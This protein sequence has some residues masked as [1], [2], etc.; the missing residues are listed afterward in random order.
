MAERPDRN[1]DQ[2]ASKLEDSSV[3]LKT[4]C[5]LAT[6]L[7]DSLETWCQGNT[8]NQFLSRFVPIFLKILDGQPVF[9]STSPEQRLRNTVLEILHRLPQSPSEPLQPYAPQ[10]VDKLMSLVKI[11]NEDNAVLCMKTIMDF[12]R[13]QTS[14]LLEKVQPFLNLIQE[15]FQ[16]ME[17]AV[18]DTLDN[19][20]AG[21]PSGVPST[22]GNSQYSQSPRPGSP[23]ASAPDIGAEQQQT[24]QL[25][26]GMSSF[27][28]L[29]ECPIIV[30]SLFQSYRQCV[31]RNVKQ[32]IPLI[33][34][35]LM[36]QAK[37]QEK[38]HAEAKAQ[39]RIFTGVSK[40]IRNRAAFG[41]FITAQVKTMSF[42][43][44]LLR[45]Y[46]QQL[47]DFLPVL[48]D[49]IVRLLKDCPKE[50]S[51]ARKEL[52]V[53]IRHII[54]FNFRK[55]FLKRLDELLDERTLIGDGLTVYESLRPLAYSMLADL[56]HHV[57]ESLSREQIRRTIEVYTKNLHDDY[58]GT[59]FQTMSAKLLLNMAECIAKLENKEDGRH[60]LIMILNAIGDKF[61]AMNRQYDNA[62]KMSNQYANQS[63]EAGPE[64]FMADK[65]HP[66]DWDEVD[67]FG[68]TPIKTWNPR[69]RESDPV[70]N[71]KF[72]FKNLLH[73]LKNLFYQLRA[74]NPPNTI[75]KANTPANW[76]EVSY[77]F[78]AEEVEVFVKLLREGAHVFRYYSLDEPPT[79][80]QSMSPVELLANHHM[81]ASSKEEKELLESF[82]TVF[83]HV[84]P[85]TFHEIFHSEIPHLY[86]MMFEHPSLLHIPQFLLASEATSPAFAGMLFQFLM[87]R[88]DDV[89]SKDVK[90]ASILLRL[91]KLAFMAVTLFSQ[92]NEP[93]LLPHVTK[94]ITKSIQLSTTAEEPINYFILLRSLFRSIGGGRFEHLYKEILPLLEML[95]EVLNNLLQSA[96]KQSDRDLYVELS[97]T[98]PARL[99]NLLPH[100]SYLMRPLVVALGAGTELVAQGLRTLELCVDNLTADYLDP[101]MAPVIDELMAALW[102]HL[103]P[104]P[105]TH[106]HAHTTMRILG[107]LGGRNRKFL[108]RPPPLD[109][110]EYADDECSIDIK[111]IGSTRDR[112]MPVRMGIDVAIE[113]LSDM[114]K[115]ASAKQSDLFYKRH[116]F[117]LIT[118]ELKL[119]IGADNLPDD[120]AQLVRLQ[121]NDLREGKYD[122]GTDLLAISEREKSTAKRDSEQGTLRKLLN[123]LILACTLPDLKDEASA[124]LNNV[125]RHFAILEVGKALAIEKHRQKPFDV[126]SGEGPVVLDSNVLADSLMDSLSSEKIEVREV[127]ERTILNVRDM[128]TTIFGS[129]DR[130]DKFT[131]FVHLQRTFS[132][133]C[134]EEQWFTKAGGALGLDIMVSKLGLSDEWLV[135]R[136]RELVVALLYV[137][138][139][140]PSD[141]PANMRA[142]AQS[143]IEHILQRCHKNSTKEDL[144]N[145]TSKLSV[146]CATLVMELNH[147]NKHV[148]DATQ[149]IFGVLAKVVGVEVYEL[150]A[151]V[152]ERILKP[153]YLKPI[154]ALPFAHQIGHID[155]M[156]FLLKLEHGIVEINE[157]TNRLLME[158]LALAD[159]DD[160]HL[161]P[162]PLEQ[163]NAELVIKFRVACIR[164]LSTAMD[165][166]E[167]Q[168]TPNSTTSRAR[169]I[170]VFFKSLYSKAPD[171]VEAAEL[172]LKGVL[173][174][175]HKLP[176]DLLQNGLR[177]ILMNL[178]DP[179]KLSVDGLEGLAKLLTL[180][181]NYFKVE[182]GSRLLD[183]TKTIADPTSLQK[184]SF[185]LI[186]QNRQMKVI[187]AILNVFHLLPPQALGFLDQLVQKVLE[188]EKDLRRTHYSP[189][190]KP[191]IQYLNRYSSEAWTYFKER[192]K[193]HLHGRFFAQLLSDPLSG[194][195]RE[196]VTSDLTGFQSALTMDTEKNE[197]WIAAMNAIHA[198]KSICSFPETS[199]WLVENLD[200]RK[201]LLASAITLERKLRD[202]AIDTHL[203]LSAEQSGDQM[204][205][206]IN[207]Y[208]SND[209][210]NFDFLFEVIDAITAGNLKDCPS[211]V[212]FIYEKLVCNDSVDYQRSLVVRGIEQYGSRN[213]SQ[214][215]KTYALHYIV[216]PIFAMDI[217]RNWD[218]LW[219]MSKGT[220]LFDKPML[221]TVHNKLWK[222]AST[223]ALVEDGRSGVDHSRLELLQLTTLLVKYHAG[224][225][226]DARKD[227]IKFGWNYIKLEDIIN[228]QAAYVLI[229]YFIAQYDTPAKITLQVYQALLKAH[230]NEGRALVAQGMEV[231]APMLPKRV[232][233]VG[234]KK[235]PVWAK[236]AKRILVEESSN[237]Q[238]LTSIFQFIVRHEDL[239]YEARES[240]A[241][242]IMQSLTKIASPPNP[243]NDQK[244]LALNLITLIWKWEERAS[245]EAASSTPG[246]PVSMKRRVDG[247]EVANNLT[248]S[249]PQRGF[250]ANSQLRLM[251]VK[252]LVQFIAYIP[253]RYPVP[254]AADKE[255]DQYQNIHQSQGVEMCKKSLRLLQGLLSP[256]YWSDLD[257]DNLFPRVTEQILTSEPKPEEKPEAWTTKIVNTLQILKVLVNVKSDEWVLGRLEQLQKLLEKP[258]RSEN[259]EIQDC[260]HTLDEDEAEEGRTKLVPLV[261]RILD[262]VP[263]EKEADE[264]EGAM[265]EDKDKPEIITYLSNVASEMISGGNYVSSINI[266]W[267]LSKRKPAELDQH[268][269]QVMKAL[270]TKLAKDHLAAQTSPQIPGGMQNPRPGGP[271]D[272]VPDP[273][274][275]EI[276]TDLIL[277]VIE[278]VAVRMSQLG[279][280]RRPYL[281]VL[282]SLV[283]RSQSSAICS[284]ILDMVSE[285]VFDSVEPVPT[286]KEK[287]AVLHKMLIFEQKADEALLNKFLDLV[288]RIYEDPKITRSELTVRMEYAFLIGTRAHNVEMRNR[289]MSIFDKSLSRTA[290]NR[291]KYVLASQNWDTLGE[292]FWLKQVIQLLFGSVEMHSHTSLHHEDF[293]VPPASLFFG[294]YKGDERL[295]SVMLDDKLE[296]LIH[297]HKAFNASLSDVRTR[298]ILE[299]LSQLQHTDDD[300]AHNIWVAF[301]PICW[302]VLTKDDRAELEK[303]LVALLTKDFHQRQIDRRPNCVG[304]ILEGI[305]KAQP[306]PKF[307]S[308]ILKY[309]ARTYDAWYVAARMLEDY[310]IEPLVDTPKIRESNLDALLEIYSSLEEDDLFYGT[311]R[312]RCQFVETNAALSY[313]Q[314]GMWDK[315]QQMYETAQ[316]KARTGTLP[317]AQGEYMLWEDHWVHCAQKLQQWEIL[318]DFAKHE[319]FNDLYL[320]STWRTFEAWTN[321][322]HRE[323]LDSIV[324]SVSDA[325]TMRRVFFQAF[326]ALLKM[327]SKQESQ[328]ELNRLIDENIQLSIRK[329]HQLP[330][331]IT[332]AHIPILQNFQQLVEL[333][334]A[335]V[336][337]NSL[338]QTSAQNLDMKSQE[339][340]M[341]LGTWRDRLP[342]FWDDINAWQSLVTWRQHIFQLING[343]Y[344]NL[345]PPQAGSATGSSFAY[346][347]YHETAWIINRFAHVARKHQMPEV[348]IN[349]LSRIYTLPNIEIQEAFLKLREQAKC[350][351]QN[352]AELSSGLDV[353]N[354]TN[355]SYFGAQ[356]K[357]EFYTLKGMF[358]DKLGDK[359]AANDAFGS[360]LYFDIKLPKAW[361]EWGRYNDMLF[362]VDPKAIDKG[363]NAISCYL[364][365]AG[366][367]KS[368]KSRKLISRV[369]W[370][371]SLDDGEETLAKAFEAYKG[372]TPVWYWITFIPQLLLGLSRPE[373]RLLRSVLLK[374]AK[375]YP[376]ALYFQLRTS[377]EDLLAIKKQNEAKAKQAKERA[378]AQ[379]QQNGDTGKQASPSSRPGTGDGGSSRPGTANGDT[380]QAPSQNSGQDAA[381]TNGA[382]QATPKTEAADGAN[383]NTSAQAKSQDKDKQP[384]DHADELMT[385]LKT[386]YP[387][388]SLS[389]EQLVDSMQQKF[390]CPPDEDAYRL[391]VALLNDGLQW[392]GR[393]PAQYAKTQKLPAP[394]EMNIT[395]FSESILPTHIRKFFE[396]DF[397]KVKPTAYEY[398][399]KLRKWRDR[400]E[401]KL[402]RRNPRANLEH[403]S[404]VLNDFRFQKFDDV[405]VPGQ[406]LEHRDKNQDF[407]RIERLMPTVDLVRGIGVCHRRIRIRGHDGSVHPFAVQHPASRSSR[408][409]ERML[410]LF[411]TF[412]STLAKKKESRRRN[413][414]FHLPEMIP[415]SPHVRLVQDDPSYITLQGVYEDYARQNNFS[416]DE[417]ILFTIEKLQKLSSTRRDVETS[418]KMDTFNAVQDKYVPQSLLKDYMQALYPSFA[419]YFLFRRQFAYQFATLTFMTYII[420]MTQRY[421]HK[422][423]ISRSTGDVWGVDLLPSI[424]SSRPIFINTEPVPFRLTPNV[425]VFLGPLAMEGIFA[426]VLQTLSRC[427]V[428][429]LSSSSDDGPAPSTQPTGAAS[430]ASGSTADAAKENATGSAGIDLDMQLSI[431]IRDEVHF[432]FTQAHRQPPTTDQLREHV[433][434]NSKSIVKKTLSLASSPDMNNLP[435][436]QTAIDLI[437][438]AVA[439]ML[440]CQTDPLWMGY[441]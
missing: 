169:I 58:P 408:R 48:P 257:F 384:W 167:F 233:E 115:P 405:E 247:T 143:T 211:F 343:T 230:Q 196:A 37:P 39:G 102:R 64:D 67:I 152:K 184:I 151:P 68:A 389:M 99:S 284:K 114:T 57:R 5:A 108:N 406:Y 162:K 425:Q 51:A 381:N 303:G 400:F 7:R 62:I 314:N 429:P 323:Q 122:A 171:V 187:T 412:N 223:E 159:S 146:M 61:A 72:L 246:S 100:L 401:E 44:Y 386:A 361:A 313:E 140:L 362:R 414:K 92:Q 269:P 200:L 239:F 116:A 245:K 347:G 195:L 182:I 280:Q 407:I 294:T 379:G 320:E 243:S 160:E 123:A 198:A 272:G 416:K 420:P 432:W 339:L 309:L 23:A 415:L 94:L 134:Y 197:R 281:S 153:I 20:S 163:R 438:K 237:L 126:M 357:A 52:L 241:P 317:F 210:R 36:L 387:L 17:Q 2:I 227:V 222:P 74:C 350:H 148:R 345:V 433:M 192:L 369:L 380:S 235:I 40:E 353:I 300:L 248:S 119:F 9:I 16:M 279:E 75:D 371:L 385:V 301:F 6:E 168:D 66:P 174:A 393:Q 70:S 249:S 80:Y 298:D 267:T 250:V 234:D 383:G 421:P 206:I 364:E 128:V 41:E 355:L 47:T 203:R 367:Y 228:K 131:F 330:K 14:V 399:H 325:P 42:L 329:W 296:S 287:T 306:R 189:F 352:K 87:A 19:T 31:P 229:A 358:Q 137:M 372:E 43:A 288:I 179:R 354:N 4:K 69:D 439:P 21:A 266:L 242:T 13:H 30:V 344:L 252:Y 129:A 312:R 366:Q 91:F 53:A 35:I 110:K 136:Q 207:V 318:S 390:K 426:C 226:I 302:S 342:N 204:M 65:N 142:Q 173:A 370:L 49:I 111:M 289:F 417:P 262:A 441:L 274:E 135:D 77:G 322:E 253:E 319:N 327:H 291:V 396:Q 340:K 185:T 22:P 124:M 424:H 117:K 63:M 292:S 410:Q 133:A 324:K 268:I 283:E 98:V 150:V 158:S 105:Y 15:M 404:Q 332:K 368:A 161:T 276:I 132:H 402:D 213:A 336:I 376:Q 328:P 93:V 270:Q 194:P 127:A 260:L 154:R 377:K 212:T 436:N 236:M 60:F 145:H 232:G 199:K 321:N 391:I 144:A 346:R 113:K 295:N 261:K 12:E 428:E 89:G 24:R 50:K 258:L 378:Q 101:I 365:A 373:A 286:L 103:R 437:A 28:V 382:A 170:A 397:V 73:G 351:Y 120:F 231:L 216:N 175:T 221:E 338:S 141:L 97:L 434:G 348:C 155:A 25:I 180:L 139:D 125:C 251:M 259:P 311:W 217:K 118:S 176:K 411:R 188:L 107:K 76:A 149:K 392:I 305:G 11:E 32:F 190:R 86:D 56:I 431:F 275:Q 419:D 277:K 398:I 104:A 85:A 33:K 430:T 409:E 26:K 435:C 1:P 208:L 215:T 331:R 83:H 225:V 423:A 96:R 95:L 334:D 224:M 177:P 337:S 27:K 403:Y 240:L 374:I 271:Q 186:E 244:K 220:K 218:S 46:A 112:A 164:L 326:L 285:W 422:I 165:F 304:T 147:L 54:N 308:H 191:L 8:Y 363:G 29:A 394:T 440:L 79:D 290:S 214:K 81:V 166:K 10:I 413:L 307:P 282:A 109:Y 205:D 82:G 310:A 156:T 71:N 78:N 299:P 55:I 18:K 265:E 38:A 201:S 202:N 360:A 315:A 254:S 293:R 138:K 130:F 264:E 193:D 178:Q 333:H 395:R 90:K 418:L 349:Q 3:D 297:A 388:L 183:H 359:E 181:T 238:Q 84:D 273:H 219:G 335:A 278:L 121:A 157:G 172:G 106:F 45:V 375:N 255:S 59:S 427:L 209:S 34:A 341:L 316:I 356:Q 88:I 263:D 256:A